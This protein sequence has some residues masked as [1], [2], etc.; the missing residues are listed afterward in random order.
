MGNPPTKIMNRTLK[1]HQTPQ[2]EITSQDGTISVYEDGAS[3]VME[4]QIDG[5]RDSYTTREDAMD[6][7]GKR[8]GC[9]TDR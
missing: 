5:D 4:D 3:W 8:R 9:P 6:A 2:G 7:G 1:W